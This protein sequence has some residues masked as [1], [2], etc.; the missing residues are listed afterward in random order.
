MPRSDQPRSPQPARSNARRV[1]SQQSARHDG[2]NI[3][4]VPPVDGFLRGLRD[5]CTAN[6]SLL[7]FDEVISGF[8]AAPGG[9][10]AIFDVAPD[11]TCLGKIIGGGLPV[12]AY[13]GR[14][15]VMSLVAPAGPVYQAGTLSGNP[16]AMTAGLWA[17]QRLLPR[18]YKDL[19]RRGAMLAAGLAAAARD[20]GVPLQVNAFGS[21]VTPFFTNEPVRD[22]ESAVRSNTA[23][24]AT[25][26]R[27]MLA[28]GIYP[29]PSQFEAWFLSG[30][31]TD[32][33]ITKTIAAARSS[34]KEVWKAARG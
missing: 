31:H 4:V 22:Y 10:Q 15:D 1:G 8:R 11:L 19:A 21:L 32:R 23:A 3:G 12:G 28:R 5:R 14:A 9:A 24:Y 29:P 20:A 13:G 18:L 2:R 25:F 33:D 7:V 27:A 34:M 30:A 6:G 16:V 17:L 26:F